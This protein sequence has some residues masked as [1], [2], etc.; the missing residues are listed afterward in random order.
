MERANSSNQRRGWDH[1]G[2]GCFQSSDRLIEACTAR[3]VDSPQRRA[4]EA[5][6]LPAVKVLAI[7]E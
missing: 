6:I 3:G 2:R 7:V 1:S 5:G 4:I